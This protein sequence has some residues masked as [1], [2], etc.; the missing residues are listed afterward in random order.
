MNTLIM[1]VM[2]AQGIPAPAKPDFSGQWVINAAESDFGIIPPP[3]CRGLTL[4]HRE[5]EFV[6]EETRPEGARCG[7][8]VRYTTDGAPVT[9]TTND[10]LMR[11]R[12]TWAGTQL[13]INRT[14]DDGVSM[15]IEVSVSPDG[16]KLTRA[17]HVE[18]PQGAA[19]WTY[20]YDR[21]R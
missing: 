14:S 20:V 13:V 8:L 17:Y 4:T 16:K 2:L 3:Q 21:A 18:S 19:D 10:T 9:Y 7:V 1:F 15:R 12:L 11:A 5:P 6:V